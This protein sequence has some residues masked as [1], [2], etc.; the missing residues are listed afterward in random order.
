ML[1]A[2]QK[3]SVRSALFR[4]I[5]ARRNARQNRSAFLFPGTVIVRLF[6]IASVAAGRRLIV[7]PLVSRKDRL[8]QN[9]QLAALIRPPAA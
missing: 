6:P 4:A 9:I 2:S 7:Y 5:M 3:E 1:A 8:T